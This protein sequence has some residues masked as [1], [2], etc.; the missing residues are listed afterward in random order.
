MPHPARLGPPL[1]SWE[2]LGPHQKRMQSQKVFDELRK[3]A[4]ARDIDPGRLT[5]TLLHRYFMRTLFG[6]ELRIIV[7]KNNFCF[8]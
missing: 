5:G 1:K 8:R 3:T 2:S 7:T 4:T 6:R